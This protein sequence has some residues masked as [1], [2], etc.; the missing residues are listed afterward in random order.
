MAFFVRINPTNTSPPDEIEATARA[1]VGA[2]HHDTVLRVFINQTTARY[3]Y[4]FFQTTFIL[5]DKDDTITF[6]LR[7]DIPNTDAFIITHL[8]TDHMDH[9]Q[10]KKVAFVDSTTNIP[11][12]NP[13]THYKTNKPKKVRYKLDIKPFELVHLGV[14]VEVKPN[15]GGDSEF[16]LCDPQVGNGPP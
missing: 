14:I 13:S 10:N 11:F 15:A 3:D 16:I 2:T 7:N 9:N 5:W 1:A 6:N 12:P 8:S 4:Q